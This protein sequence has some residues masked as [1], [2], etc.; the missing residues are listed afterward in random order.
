MIK[1]FTLLFK[2][3]V[4]K[5]TIKLFVA[6]LVIVWT[7]HNWGLFKMLFNFET[8][9][10]FQD[11]MESVGVFFSSSIIVFFKNLVVCIL[12][13]LAVLISIYILIWLWRLIKPK[14]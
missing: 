13:T 1:D 3:Y 4:K 8:G 14:Q 12:I 6:L 5:K 11:K 2:K 10:S 9:K 7:H